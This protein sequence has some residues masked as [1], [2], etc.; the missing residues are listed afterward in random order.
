[1]SKNRK[2]YLFNEAKKR[3]IEKIEKEI[4][5]TFSPRLNPRSR[6]IDRQIPNEEKQTKRTDIIYGYAEKYSKHKE[7]LKQFYGQKGKEDLLFEPKLN[8]KSIKMA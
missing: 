7:D 5:P 8:D 6:D 2:N 1:M 4:T 3:N